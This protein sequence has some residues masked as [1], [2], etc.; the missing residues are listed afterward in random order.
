MIDYRNIIKNRELRLKLIQLLRFIPDGPY[1]KM[2]YW[3]KTGKKLNLKNPQTFCDKLNW[4]K[5]HD[6][7][8][9]Y[10]KLV[11]KI[12]VKEIV[13]EQLG[14]DCCFATLGVY[15]HYDDIDFDVLPEQFVMKCNHDSG[16]VKIINNKNEINHKELKHFFESRL[17]INQFLLG[18]EY[19]YK[20]IK[21]KIMIEKYMI[22]TGQGSI[23]D[24]KFFC[25]NGSPYVLYVVS[26]RF[27][28]IRYDFYD[29]NWNH[30]NITNVHD[31]SDYP[32]T[33][34]SNFEEMKL[35][36]S[37]L[38]SN[39]KHVRIDLYTTEDK[40]YFGEYTF[41]HAGGFWPMKPDKW[42]LELGNLIRL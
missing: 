10:S 37:K 9:E 36:V 26:D 23:K 16:G 34:P 6:R 31:H 39:M 27:A 8:P 15:D 14:Y 19:V 7:N 4:L 20:D 22:P 17:K 3:I 35:I 13:K 30:L 11:D 24:Y 25:F 21:P 2:V 38:S 29:M 18:R 5:L 33:M 42:E 41:F 40:I 28:D 12:A 32:E 1:L